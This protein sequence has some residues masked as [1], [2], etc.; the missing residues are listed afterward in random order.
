MPSMRVIARHRRRPGRQGARDAVAQH[1]RVAGEEVDL[2]AGLQRQR[3]ARI[4]DGDVFE[5][6]AGLVP[7]ALRKLAKRRDMRLLARRAA[8][9]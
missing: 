5:Q 8:E 6:P 4:V 9:R 7:A 3:V 2:V 1:A